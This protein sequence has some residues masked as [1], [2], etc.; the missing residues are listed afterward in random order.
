MGLW[1]RRQVI[2]TALGMSALALAGCA[3]DPKARK[4][5]GE[6]EAPGGRQ[7]TPQVRNDLSAG[8]HKENQLADLATAVAGADAANRAKL[9]ALA[10]AHRRHSAVLGAD[11]PFD[12]QACLLY[13][14]PSPRDS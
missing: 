13:T 1:S 5:R 3:P 12:A 6:K 10:A 8:A 9:N 7:L 2:G 14:S 4:H 11:D